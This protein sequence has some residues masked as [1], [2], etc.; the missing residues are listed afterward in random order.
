VRL[1]PTR[2]LSSYISRR[3]AQHSRQGVLLAESLSR[4]QPIGAQWD[5]VLEQRA[6]LRP[7]V[8]AP[9]NF[10]AV[11][12]QQAIH[13]SRADRQQP[14]LGRRGQA[15]ATARSGDPAR[16]QCLQPQGPRIP[17]HGP[18]RQQGPHHRRAIPRRPTRPPTPARR[19]RPHAPRP[20]VAPRRC[21][22][23]A[24]RLR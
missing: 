14:R 11:G 15:Q 16:Q 10:L 6:R 22:P 21:P 24:H 19:P 9:L 2:K 3:F 18:N 1:T 23:V 8:L 7:A 12:P 13:L 20:N 4:P 5:V 17:G